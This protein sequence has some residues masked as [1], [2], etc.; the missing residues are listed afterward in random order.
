MERSRK[1]RKM[2]SKDIAKM[3]LEQTLAADYFECAPEQLENMKK[4][5]LEIL[6]RYMNLY[7]TKEIQL[8]FTQEIK[9]GVQYVK[10]VQIKGL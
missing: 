1:S 9:Q 8:S 5:I 2:T 7:D 6:S 3:R 10:T 4:E